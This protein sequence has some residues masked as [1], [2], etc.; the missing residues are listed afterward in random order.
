M[1]KR[2]RIGKQLRITDNIKAC[3]IEERLNIL[4]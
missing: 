2:I 4:V 1:A 3:E